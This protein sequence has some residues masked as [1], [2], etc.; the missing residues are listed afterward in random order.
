MDKIKEKLS[1]K[2]LFDNNIRNRILFNFLLLLAIAFLVISVSFNIL[3]SRYIENTAENQLEKATLIVKNIDVEGMKGPE[4]KITE[5]E[6]FSEDEAS[7]FR[8]LKDTN[9][10]IRIAQENSDAEAMAIDENYNML[11]PNRNNDFLKNID[12]LENICEEMKS[13]NI[14]PGEGGIRRIKTQNSEYYITSVKATIE[15]GKEES[16]SENTYI[17]LF[18]NITN[19]LVLINGINA[20]LATIMFVVG[21]F[22]VI[23]SGMISEKIAK[24]I[25]ELSGFAEDIGKG[26][27]KR[28]KFSFSDREFEEMAEVMNKS[29]EYLDNRNKEQTVFFQNISHELRT[30]LMSINGY[31]E[32]IKYK[33]MNSEDAADVILKESENLKSMI[34]DII[35]IS[36]MDSDMKKYDMKV[37]DLREIISSCVSGRNIIAQNKGV[38]IECLFDDSEIPIKCDV[39]EF[40]K[41]IENII[42]NCIRYANNKIT[43]ECREDRKNITVVI[44]DDGKG[45]KDEDLPHI[46]ERFYKGE[47]GKHGIGLSISKEV[48]NRHGGRIYAENNE[49]GGAKFTIVLR[50]IK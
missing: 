3:I 30:P 4:D 40:S 32:A 34:E 22:A 47:D 20:M 42:G 26:D 38:K 48:I 36:K 33:I 31:A 7:I 29:A 9:N 17:V 44:S 37:H 10:R 18:V 28:R 41:A 39:R 27:F 49:K 11:L 43:V 21:I 13:E 14:T 19:N 5:S 16:V 35:Y 8:F 2:R 12:E 23:V 6:I 25:N 45:I 24:P 46:F 50:K 1:K 15:S